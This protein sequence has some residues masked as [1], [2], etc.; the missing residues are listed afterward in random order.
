ML[1][2]VKDISEWHLGTFVLVNFD[3]GMIDIRNILEFYAILHDHSGHSDCGVGRHL[4]GSKPAA[5]IALLSKLGCAIWSVLV[6]ADLHVFGTQSGVY[7]LED[8]LLQRRQLEGLLCLF[9]C[10]D[11]PRIPPNRKI[12]KVSP[13]AGLSSFFADGSRR[14]T[15]SFLSA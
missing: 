7:L 1:L 6:R 2:G 11:L 14:Q 4:H 10:G 5:F 13:S 9:D 8:H 15:R 12:S 3:L